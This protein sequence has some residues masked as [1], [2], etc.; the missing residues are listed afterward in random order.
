MPTLALSNSVAY[1]IL[2]RSG[3]DTVKAFPPIR[4]F[5]TIGFICTMWI[6]DILGYQT[7]PMRF[8]ISAFF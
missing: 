5:G 4:V 6:V 1:T 2:D 3:L 8:I 7:T